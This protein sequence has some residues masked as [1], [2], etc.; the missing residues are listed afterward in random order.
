[1]K[2]ISCIGL[3]SHDI[4]HSRETLQNLVMRNAQLLL[5]KYTTK[6]ITHDV[7]LI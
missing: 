6:Q 4:T 3:T 7:Q 5:S 2:L 1:M